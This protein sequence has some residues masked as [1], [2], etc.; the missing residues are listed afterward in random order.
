MEWAL[1]CR[2]KSREPVRNPTLESSSAK[3]SATR[4][5]ART[6]TAEA[7]SNQSLSSSESDWTPLVYTSGKNV[8]THEFSGRRVWGQF[9]LGSTWSGSL[10]AYPLDYGSMRAAQWQ[11]RDGGGWP[12]Y[13]GRIGD[14]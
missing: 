8:E 12:G 10:P 1:R 11:R 5:K 14:Q 9:R 3:F 6:E 4:T 13:A 2:L 7:R